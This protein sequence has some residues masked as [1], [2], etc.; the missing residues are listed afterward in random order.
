MVESML[1]SLREHIY[2][3][4]QT[5]TNKRNWQHW[6]HETQNED[7]QNKNPTRYVFDSTIYIQT[8]LT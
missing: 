2:V 5:W 6:V 7:K 8:Q 1:I 4:F 3:L